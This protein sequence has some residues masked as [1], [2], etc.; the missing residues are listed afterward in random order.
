MLAE[1]TSETMLDLPMSARLLWTLL[2]SRPQTTE[3]QR[4]NLKRVKAAAFPFDADVTV[5]TLMLDVLELEER[6]LLATSVGPDGRERYRILTRTPDTPEPP[7]QPAH[8]KH[9][10]TVERER[11]SERAREQEPPPHPIRRPQLTAP[12]RYC[13]DHMPLGPGRE[14]CVL[15]EQARLSTQLWLQFVKKGQTPPDDLSTPPVDTYADR[16]PDPEPRS[17]QSGPPWSP[18]RRPRFDV[19]DPL[20]DPESPDYVPT[21][22]L[23][24]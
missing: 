11:E 20:D 21:S 3:P 12:A 19:P 1:L 13:A 14:P 17:P 4:L 9:I 8:S 24:F 22:R 7:S 18:R 6:G 2:S 5:D 15:C 10:A 16:A 23:P